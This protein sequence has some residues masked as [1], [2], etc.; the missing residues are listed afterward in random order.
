MSQVSLNGDWTLTSPTHSQLSI[1]M[2]VPGDN[3]HALLKA[4][5]ITDPYQETNEELV[6]WVRECDWH[7]SRTFSLSQQELNASSLF[8]NL[9][10]LDTL[11]H[12]FINGELVLRST[13]MFQLHR[14]NIKPFLVLGD[15]HIEVHFSRVDEE[16]KQRA[17]ALPMPIPWAVG[18]NQVPHMNLIRKTQCHSGWDWGICLLVSGIYDPVYIDVIEHITL[19]SVHTEQIWHQENVEVT[20]TIHHDPISDHEI[21]VSFGDQIQMTTTSETGITTVTFRIDQ[22]ELW[23][24]AGYGK[25]PLYPLHVDLNNQSISKK[26]GLRSLILNNKADTIGSAM[27]FVI[28]G[29]P[30]N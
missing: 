28:N 17:N 10:R 26:I 9:S 25:Q 8:L 18:N 14:I 21:T 6:Q 11:A 23:W 20:A 12:V 13:N 7:V 24:P 2:S 15:N 27:E 1:P 5:I 29:F 16:G 30:I 19:L 3:Y 22:P 4:N